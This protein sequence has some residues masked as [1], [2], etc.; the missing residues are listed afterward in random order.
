MLYYQPNGICVKKLERFLEVLTYS[1][2]TGQEV[3]SNP[4]KI[5]S[6]LSEAFDEAFLKKMRS[7]YIN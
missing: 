6:I 3:F 4:E 5:L 2:F 7:S 1:L